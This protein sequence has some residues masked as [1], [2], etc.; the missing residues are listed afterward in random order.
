MTSYSNQWYK[1]VYLTGNQI[2][3]GDPRYE[4]FLLRTIADADGRFRFENVPPG[5]YYLVSHI[6]WEIPSYASIQYTGG[7]V[8]SIIQVENDKTT[9]AILTR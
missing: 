5:Y 9:E 1:V 6:V 7:Y 8:C 3:V 2:A 4:S